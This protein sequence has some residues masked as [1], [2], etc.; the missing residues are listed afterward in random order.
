MIA[1][2]VLPSSLLP[3]NPW[4]KQGM[5]W[6]VSHSL[7]PRTPQS[8]SCFLPLCTHV[9]SIY[10]EPGSTMGTVGKIGAEPRAHSPLEV[11]GYRKELGHIYLSGSEKGRLSKDNSAPSPCT[12]C[13]LLNIFHT[14]TYQPEGSSHRGSGVV[15]FRNHHE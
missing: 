1:A 11:K 9:L 14:H 12:S 13:D 7:L 15:F 6:S 5:Q 10:S 3:G 4:V 2:Q 8:S